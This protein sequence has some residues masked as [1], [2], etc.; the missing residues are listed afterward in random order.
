[1]GDRGPQRHEAA[2]AATESPRRAGLRLSR[3]SVETLD[4]PSTWVSRAKA[5]ATAAGPFSIH[6]GE[7]LVKACAEAGVHYVDTSDEFYWQR[8][9]IDRYH[10]T[11]QRSGAK[12]VL[13]SGFCV[14]AAD[15]GAH[16]ALAPFEGFANYSLDAWLE[17]YSGGISA[18]V[19]HTVKVNASYPKEWDTDPYVLAPNAS[20]ALRVDTLVP[21][22]KY[23]AEV[24][25]EGLIVPSLFGAYD[26]RLARRSF[27]LR[28]DPMAVHMRVGATPKMYEKWAELILRH[29]GS[30][31]SL[32]TCPTPELIRDGSWSYK[33]NASASGVSTHLT[34]VLS[35]S[36]DPG[37]HFT[38]AGLAEVALCLSGY[39]SADC[40]NLHRPV[41]VGVLTPGRALNVSVFIERL[42]RIGLMKVE[43]VGAD[44]AAQVEAR[45][46]P[47]R[48]AGALEREVARLL[49]SPRRAAV[50]QLL[51][52][53]PPPTV[54]YDGA[55]LVATRARLR[56]G[57]PSLAASAKALANDAAL[58]LP[59]GPWSVTE[60]TEA[61]PG[62][63]LHD[64]RSIGS[65]WWP[66][67]EECNASLFA[68]CSLWHFSDLGPH[69]PPYDNCS[70]ATGLPWYDHDGYGNP[71]N[72]A[73]DGPRLRAMGGAVA[74]LALSGFLLDNATHSA[75]AAALVRAW[76]VTPATRMRPSARFSQGIPGRCDG[77]GIGLID[78]HDAF[79]GVVDAA[80]LL[81]QAPGAP[82]SATDRAALLAWFTEWL[83]W[84]VASDEG[85][86]EAAAQNNHGSF[87]DLMAAGIA[88]YAANH[89]VA[90]A[91]CA[92]AP[93]KRIAVQV[94]PDGSLP[95][96]D[97]RS[98]SQGYHAYDLEALLQL[99]ALCD[100]LGAADLFSFETAD[101][102]GLRNALAFLAPYAAGDEPWPW[103]QIQPFQREVYTPIFRWAA[104][105]KAWPQTASK[106]EAIAEKQ[107][108]AGSA[109]ANLLW[110][111]AP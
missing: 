95:L 56:A 63:D 1:M 52:D 94:A 4:D 104:R 16:V 60:K 70:K 59:K 100:R 5:V 40:A 12:I 83:E 23:P 37:Y 81:E 45:E 6:E 43:W 93:A 8:W 47:P 108:G 89:S 76:F 33:F 64:Y 77:R 61:P 109:R 73:L 92:A 53:A 88:V 110:P 106:Y 19:I 25:G 50:A 79:L 80:R 74:S 96:E 105:A 41:D 101:G 21:G 87:Y 24:P 35:G 42:E 31:S 15:L 99:A 3:S 48:R 14:L 32:T 27:V 97:K 9:M 84:Q 98:K 46:E 103:K 22:I 18:G 54:M 91:I 10:A 66:C 20:A 75:R 90:S 28:D 107:P 29:P 62:G 51:A 67:T 2:R 17:G 44:A 39:T 11:A 69:G 58:A 55:E 34:A 78:F 36:G 71:I 7:N 68:N 38:S 13:A 26:A 72:D 85:H 30:W 65:Y 49:A 86:A 82:W 102:R 111:R 57:D